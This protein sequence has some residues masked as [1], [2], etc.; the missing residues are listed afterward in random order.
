LPAP[1]RSA[2]Q[3]VGQ[4]VEPARAEHAFWVKLHAE[5]RQ[6]AVGDGHH[7][8]VVGPGG[9]AQGGGQLTQVQRVIAREQRGVRQA[10]KQAA[11]VVT[12]GVG[13]TVHRSR[14]A[15]EPRPQRHPE[16]LMTQ[17]DAEQ[18]APPAQP[19]VDPLE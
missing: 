14:R 15:L 12:D 2:A 17:T 18:R 11:A 16:R 3:K 19:G 8:S 1:N 7:E 9:A 10:G 6:L 13:L 4:Q 5:R